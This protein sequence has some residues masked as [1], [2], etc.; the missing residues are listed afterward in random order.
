MT[1][2]VLALNRRTFSSLHRHRN[3]RFFFFG[4]VVSV[5]GT[6]MQ[7]IAQAWLVLSLTRSPVAVGFLAL[8]QFLPFTVFGLLA[9]VI[10][11]RFDPRRIVISTQAVQ[12]V[13]SA[14]LAAIALAGVAQPWHVYV[15]AALLGTALVV[16]APGRQALTYRMVGPA[17]LPN[18]V[19]LNSSLFNGARIFGPGLGGLIIA[20]AGVGFC[21]A[22]NAVSY[23][24]VLAGL[25]AMRPRDFFPVEEFERPT[26]LRGI[27]EGFSYV[28]QR[29]RALVVLALVTVTSTFCFNFNVLLP[30]L[31][32]K[33]LHAG[34][35]TFGLLTALFGA[36]ALLGALASAAFGRAS[37]KA[38]VLGTGGFAGLQLLL[39]PQHSVAAAAA[40]LF[41]IGF[42]FTVWTSSSNSTLQL[43]A[44]D[45]MRGRVVGL[46][47]YAFNGAA[48][49]GGL[50]AG[51]LASKGGTSLSFAVAGT[52][53]VAMSLLAASTF[54]ERPFYKRITRL[55]PG[56]DESRPH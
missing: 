27:R 18:A 23:L 50:M 52:I 43:E 33:T 3:Y 10:V 5:T 8:A 56:S 7:R 31:A 47:Y 51:W 25:L 34:P 37:M 24:A 46:Y 20:A 17:E 49:L 45:H 39:A 53:G 14:A 11:D 6:W 32:N 4:Q 29:K 19:A 12:M 16:D 55:G 36:G 1:A 22:L 48:L 40:I 28:R 13:F 30:V 15:T 54:S 9:G 41:T 21:F 44:P 42:C 2:M 38:L 35:E 26:I